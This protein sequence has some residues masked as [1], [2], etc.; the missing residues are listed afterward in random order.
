MEF[1]SAFGGLAM[2]CIAQACC[3]YTVFRQCGCIEAEREVIQ[4]E[5]PRVVVVKKNE[6]PFLNEQKYSHY[7]T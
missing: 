7:P 5:A 1:L 6:N 3:W 4:T 2:S